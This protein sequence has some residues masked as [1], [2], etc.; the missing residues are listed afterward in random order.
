YLPKAPAQAVLGHA[1]DRVLALPSVGSKSFLITIADRTVGGLTV[2]DQM[3]GPWQ[4]P[5]AD[6]S[7]TATS[8]TPGIKTGEAMAMG[9]KPTLALISAGASARMSVVESLMNIAA[10]SVEN[11]LSKIRLS[12]NW[13]SASSHPGEGAALYEAAEAI[14]MQLCPELGVSIPVGKDSMSMKTKWEG[15]EV[16]AP[17]SLII[18]AFGPVNDISSTWTPALRRPEDVGE[19]VLMFVD[20]A[21]GKKALGGSALA[22]VFG[23]VGDEA[24][25]VRDVDFVKDFFHAIEQLHESDIVLAYH[26]RS[27]GGLFTTL[28]EMMY[29]GRCGA[30]IMLDKIVKSGRT[31]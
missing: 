15:K 13:M 2:R 27:D 12:A 18:S 11:R 6:V 9:E 5:V 30:E 3:V 22:Q 17:L 21:D 24:P 8:L 19:T 28:V 26:D 10:A 1:V 20:L 14:G 29:A 7:V 4:T 23:Q 16:T 25:D 31:Q